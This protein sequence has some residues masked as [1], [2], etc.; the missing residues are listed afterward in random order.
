M[1]TM[2]N[3]LFVLVL[4]CS[5][6]FGQLVTLT[7]TTLSAA[8]SSGAS[9]LRVASASGISATVTAPSY[10]YVLDPGSQR[11]ELMK[12]SSVSGTNIGVVRGLNGTAAVGHIS[13]A[14]VVIGRGQDF[15]GYD[16]SGAC[17]STTAPVFPWINPIN[18]N[19]WICSSV[20]G[21]WV[22]GWNNTN[23]PISATATVASAAGAILPSG[24]L[25][26][27]SG[28]AAVTGFTI[29]VGFAS[30]S[31]CTVPTG[32]FT[33]T[34]AGNINTAGTAVVGRTLCF[35]YSTTASKFVASYL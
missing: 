13:G 29:P 4:A 23:A 30:G 2:F 35:T 15:P 20:S 25:F 33:W 24:P 10:L 21:S 6:S 8:V 16:P 11:G 26:T 1:K 18:G 14:I 27:V 34:T 22:P 3:L 17:T 31:F 9:T 7:Q 19:Q 5:A 32:A 28:T 12:V